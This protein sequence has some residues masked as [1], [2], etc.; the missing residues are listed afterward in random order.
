[1]RLHLGLGVGDGSTRPNTGVQDSTLIGMVEKGHGIEALCLFLEL[2]EVDLLARVV[3]LNLYTPHNGAVRRT[4]GIR[5]A[6]QVGEIRQL[7][8]FW[9]L[10]LSSQ[11]LS[12]KL[13]RSQWSIRAKARWLG[14]PRRPRGSIIHEYAEVPVKPA[15]TKRTRWDNDLCIK[16]IDRI[17][18]YQHYV[19]VA[20]DLNLTPAQVRS[21]IKV[22][23]LPKN[24]DRKLLTMD[25]RPDSPEAKALRAR[26]VIRRCQEWGRVFV[27]ERH[28]RPSY[29][30]AFMK[31]EEGKFRMAMFG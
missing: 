29:C 17:L 13:G 26:H 18:A 22:L 9:E 20:R 10:G 16:V 1:M 24:R 12:A 8:A 28:E 14:L 21:K 2:L 31:T 30:P 25:Y 11:C 19:A 7:I 3:A 5:N 15:T 4:S 6:W 23:G 27:A